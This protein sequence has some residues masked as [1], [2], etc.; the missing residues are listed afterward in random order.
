MGLM[1]ILRAALRSVLPVRLSAWDMV[2]IVSSPVVAPRLYSVDVGLPNGL[3]T[4]DKLM[5]FTDPDLLCGGDVSGACE[6]TGDLIGEGE[7]LT[8]IEARDVKPATCIESRLP[9][10]RPGGPCSACTTS[11]NDMKLRRLTSAE[12][13]DP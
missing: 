6:D 12:S 10:A 8:P 9:V 5:P 1:G 4:G 7:R 2:S 13:N 3:R 11:A